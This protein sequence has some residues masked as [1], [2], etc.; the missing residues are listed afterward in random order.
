MDSVLL[1]LREGPR[2]QKGCRG[3][4]RGWKVKRPEQAGLP[5]KTFMGQKKV[6][7]AKAPPSFSRLIPHQAADLPRHSPCNC[8][9]SDVTE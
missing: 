4:M 1:S 8:K 5:P 9:S 3:A 7:R 6:S 2:K